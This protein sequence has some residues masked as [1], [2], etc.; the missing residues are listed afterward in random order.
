MINKSALVLYKYFSLNGNKIGDV[1]AQGFG[2]GLKE[3]KSLEK[4]QYVTATP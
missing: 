4:L 1:G 2:E 3:N